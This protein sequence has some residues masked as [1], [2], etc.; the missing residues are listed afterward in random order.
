MRPPKKKKS[1]NR[2]SI[3]KRNK[4]LQNVEPN[5]HFRISLCAWSGFFYVLDAYPE[6]FKPGRFSP[7]LQEG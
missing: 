4:K 6:G 2:P 5:E 7:R 1:V 3:N